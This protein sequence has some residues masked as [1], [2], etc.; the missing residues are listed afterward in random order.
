MQAS[1]HDVHIPRKQSVLDVCLGLPRLESRCLGFRVYGRSV[2]VGNPIASSLKS[3]V[4]GIPAQFGLS[5]VY[6]FM[7]F[8]VGISVW[9]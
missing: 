2:K 4:W 6:N 3:N 8:T 7:G 9:V 1:C 5:P